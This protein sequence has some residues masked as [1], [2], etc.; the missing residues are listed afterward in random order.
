MRISISMNAGRTTLVA[1]F[2]IISSALLAV[3][4]EDSV[5]PPAPSLTRPTSAEKAPDAGGFIQRWLI[6][7][8]IRSNTALTDNAIK[9]AVKKEYFPNQLGVVPRDG[10]KVKSDDSEL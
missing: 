2:A 8:P 3:A 7:E 10:D 6:L 4:G 9:E 1:T 5:P